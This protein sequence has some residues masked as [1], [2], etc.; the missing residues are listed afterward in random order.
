MNNFK[1]KKIVIW[2]VLPNIAGGQ[3]V[4]LN[5][6]AQLK[7][8]YDFKAILPSKG[9]LL[10]EFKKMGIPVEILPIGTYSLG[11][12][13]IK[14]VLRFMW[15]TPFVLSRV[16]KI[17]KDSDLIYANSSRVFVWSAI[18]GRILNIPVVWHL[19]SVLT[20]KKSRF[21]IEL[22]GK[23]KIIKKIIAVSFVTANQFSGLK[24]KIVVI[25]N[26]VD[27]LRFREIS[28]QKKKERFQEK[29]YVIGMIADLIPQKGHKTL[30]KAI[31]LIK[32]K[33]PVKL[34]IVGAPRENTKWYERELK[35]MVERF[36]LTNIV[37]F[38]GY[39]QDVFPILNQLDLLVV[40]SSSSFE[41]CPMVILE[42]YACGIPVVGSNLGGIPELIE[43]GKTGFIFK[44]NDEKELAEKILFLFRNPSLHAQM[45][46]NCRKIAE[47]KFN[48]KD[49]SKKIEKVLQEVFNK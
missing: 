17:V 9:P 37:E 44:A 19:H 32:N 31:G 10:E 1:K 20:D 5:V 25:Y 4:A 43:E 49:F 36:E 7:N 28:H 26:G 13:G 35:K 3:R 15:Y 24:H 8:K 48:L 40:P 16:A 30:I 46:K 29:N 27:I 18:V 2:E 14:D 12:K 22:F 42:A 33:I 34:L 21:L 38:L 11:R 45:K 41:A 39:R 23:S 47:Q 6:V